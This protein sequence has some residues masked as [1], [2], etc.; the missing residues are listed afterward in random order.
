MLLNGY[1]PHPTPHQRS[2]SM[3]LLS[4]YGASSNVSMRIAPNKPSI[5]L[6]KKFLRCLSSL[7]YLLAWN[8]QRRIHLP[9][10]TPSIAACLPYASQPRNRRPSICAN[11][12]TPANDT[13][14]GIVIE[15]GQKIVR[16]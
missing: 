14:R 6:W 2:L 7:A 12:P 11:A 8:C 4:I 15:D 10:T 16:P 9:F 3:T 1:R 5:M 13:T